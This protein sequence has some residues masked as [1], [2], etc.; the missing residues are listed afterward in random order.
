MKDHHDIQK[1]KAGYVKANLDLK[2]FN[3]ELESLVDPKSVTERD[4]RVGRAKATIRLKDEKVAAT[5]SKAIVDGETADLRMERDVAKSMWDVCKA[6]IE[7]CHKHIES[8][9]TLV[10]LA[11]T[12][13]NLK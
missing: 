9:R 6:N 4:Y 11:K 8:Y 3:E 10:S 7:R 13:I 1:L 5:I 12:E 2:T